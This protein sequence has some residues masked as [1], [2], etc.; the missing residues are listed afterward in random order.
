MIHQLE[1]S[2]ASS[3]RLV[4][5]LRTEKQKDSVARKALITQHAR[6]LSQLRTSTLQVTP[7]PPLSPHLS[8]R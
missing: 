4:G 5:H 8:P 6:E 2:L 7:Y 1:E 3:E